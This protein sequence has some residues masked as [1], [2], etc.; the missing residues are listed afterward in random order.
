MKPLSFIYWRESSSNGIQNMKCTWM[1]SI[2]TIFE[3]SPSRIALQ[4]FTRF[5]DNSKPPMIPEDNMV[6]EW[7]IKKKST[8]LL[9]EHG[10]DSEITL[11]FL[12]Y[13][14]LYRSRSLDNCCQNIVS[15]SLIFLFP[16]NFHRVQSWKQSLICLDICGTNGKKKK[17]KHK[18]KTKSDMCIWEPF[19]VV[20]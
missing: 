5:L 2:T 1:F 15:K 11:F 13:P 14:S 3:M 4:K 6:N 16:Q 18:Q 12:R 9:I 8:T 7:F 19:V 10:H 20:F 17:K